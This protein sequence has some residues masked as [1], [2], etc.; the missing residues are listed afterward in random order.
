MRLNIDQLKD[1]L[2]RAIFTYIQTFLGL[3]SASGLGVD[4]GGIST[5]KMAALGG[6][7]AAFSV[8]KGAVATLGPV[9]DATASCLRQQPVVPDDAENQLYE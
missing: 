5:L 7:P 3:M 1:I 6:L 9:G 8:I 2:E 4:M